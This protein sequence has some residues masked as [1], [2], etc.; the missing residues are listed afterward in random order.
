LAFLHDLMIFIHLIGAISWIGGMIF[1]SM[2]L[3]PLVRQRNSPPEFV[4]LFRAAAR[5]FRPVVWGSIG[6]LLATGPILLHQRGL[7]VVD[8]SVWP[9]VLRIK[10]GLVGVFI[11]LTAAHDLVIGPYL[12]R[13]T[14]LRGSRRTPIEQV[15]LRTS[16]W[17]PR[18]ALLVGLAILA[19]ALVLTRS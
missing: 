12:R 4:A 6:L 9:N 3:A 16:T 5:R 8:P 19:A 10:I 13:M 17:L 14:P 7:S 2:V 1:L 18:V 11:L 15:L